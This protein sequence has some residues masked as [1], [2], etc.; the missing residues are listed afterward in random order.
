[1]KI[2]LWMVVGCALILQPPLTKAQ[3]SE[4][5]KKQ[6]NQDRNHS[7]PKKSDLF[8][9]HDCGSTKIKEYDLKDKIYAAEVIGGPRII[10][11][12]NL[13]PLRYKYSVNS[14]V[15]F[16]QPPDL[17]SKLSGIASPQASPTAAKPPKSK[18]T[19][20]KAGLPGA[21][22]RDVLTKLGG[23]RSLVRGVTPPATGQPTRAAIPISQETIT[24]VDK[25]NTAISEGILAIDG[26]RQQ[27]SGIDNSLV[28]SIN[29]D[30]DAVLAEAIKANTST[31]DV[32]DAG[33]ELIRFVKAVDATNTYDGVQREL[34]PASPFMKG[35]NAS[36][37]DAANVA[38]LKASTSAR[39]TI[40]AAKKTAF[41][42][43]YPSLLKSLGAAQHDLVVARNDLLTQ[44]SKL[45]ASPRS[46]VEDKLVQNTIDAVRLV[47][48]GGDDVNN[49][50]IEGVNSA[51][52]NLQSAN[53]T[54]NWATA[55]TA[56]IEATLGELDTSGD[57]YKAFQQA[58]TTLADWQQRMLSLEL[59]WESHVKTNTADPFVL[60][61]PGTCDY[62]FSTTKQTAI[63]ITASDQLPDKT[64]APP[65]DVLS[66]TVVC[67]S[68]FTVSAG[69]A[70]ST[71]SN[72]QFSIQPVATPPG[73]TT[74]TNEF[75]LTSNSNFHPLPIGLVSARLC[76]P[77]ETVSFHL[78]FGL[79]GD[80]KS[81][82]SGGSSAEFLIGPSIA[83]FRTMFFT[84]GLHLGQQATLGNGFKVGD[85]VP[86]NVTSPPLRTSYTP[87]F[88]FAITFTKP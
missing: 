4:D 88:G 27:V 40:L 14:T 21:P 28:V 85:P 79:A 62:T 23:A 16:S 73:S 74:T 30:F 47:L 18:S 45:Q 26:V 42:V 86:T 60:R 56:S 51:A 57:K 59:S 78:S 53:D 2:W 37:G 3:T 72:H 33:K 70:F 81:Q 8:C 34:L 11:V 48:D 39:K 64:A 67:A 25:A 58:Q 46:S 54:L 69:V 9:I 24:L 31:T 50:E 75:V 38:K 19:P 52:D 43:A 76:E 6:P 12:Y 83:L 66:V 5:P 68:P 80:F 49:E 82:N 10:V 17:L 84:P 13:N 1:M 65:S 77:N 22:E 41:D 87:G 44:Q 20:D 61:I 29:H 36:W 7:S 35:V 32:G 63:K 71:I 15:S 55:K